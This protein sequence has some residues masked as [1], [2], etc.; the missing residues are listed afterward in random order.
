MEI[1]MF[2]NFESQKFLYII[3]INFQNVFFAL[4]YLSLDIYSCI[5]KLKRN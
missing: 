5:M 4:R 2:E 3:A 1:C